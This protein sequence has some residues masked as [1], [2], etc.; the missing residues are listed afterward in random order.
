MRPYNEV[1][2]LRRTEL[3]TSVPE[4]A[5]EFYQALLA[6]HVLPSASGFECWVGS[7]QC[8]SIRTCRTGRSKGWLPVLA[9]AAHN[10]VLT[11]PDDAVAELVTAR[12]RHGPRAPGPREGEPCWLELLTSSAARADEFWAEVLGWT[13][14]GT[15]VD[16]I[17]ASAGH[18]VAGRRTE[19]RA[20]DRAGWLCYFS[21]HDL[22]A[23]GNR[24]T[25]LGGEVLSRTRHS[26]LDDVILLA[27][28]DG[29]V[30]GLTE[31][32]G[33]WGP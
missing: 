9:G 23:A 11:G 31:G 6:W 25:G 27:A 10:G 14:N 21:V 16:A 33:R 3:I 20:G 29:A 1:H 19:R 24:V 17:Y 15:P 12:V 13:I 30:L 2:G 4:S 22:D 8:A 18:P 32:N 5:A 26:S 28:P 7:R